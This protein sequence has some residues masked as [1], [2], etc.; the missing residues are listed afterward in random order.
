MFR[1]G[2]RKKESKAVR[3]KV[4]G[5][6]EE[7]SKKGRRNEELETGGRK[8]RE[9]QGQSLRYTGVVGGGHRGEARKDTEVGSTCTFSIERAEER[10]TEQKQEGNISWDVRCIGSG[11]P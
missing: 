1:R 9:E 8:R 5:Y 3:I 11:V 4:R 2:D 7:A 10:T 6:G